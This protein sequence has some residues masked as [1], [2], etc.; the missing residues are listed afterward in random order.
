MK[1]YKLQKRLA[2]KMLGAGKNRVWLDPDYLKEI[3]EAITNADISVLIKDGA[4]KALPIIGVKRRAGRIRELRK[5]RR[6]ARGRGKK[7]RVPKQRKRE[8]MDR[9]RKLR[10]QLGSLRQQG[11]IDTQHYKKLRV[12]AKAGLIRTKSDIMAR[13]K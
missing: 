5:K 9:I 3:G 1:T 7:R 4:I 11:S 12:L 2:A 13:M 8:Y 6:R 10:A